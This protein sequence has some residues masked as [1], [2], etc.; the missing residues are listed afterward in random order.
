MLQQCTTQDGPQCQQWQ[1]VLPTHVDII[2]T[3]ATSAMSTTYA[4]L[5]GPEHCDEKHHATH[6]IMDHYVDGDGANSGPG[7]ALPTAMDYIQSKQ[8]DAPNNDVPE[9]L[10]NIGYPHPPTPELQ[11]IS[12]SDVDATGEEGDEHMDM[13]SPLA[14]PTCPPPETQAYQNAMFNQYGNWPFPALEV[15]HGTALIYDRV[16]AAGAPNYRGARIPLPS[17]LHLEVWAHEATGHRDDDTIINGVTYGFPIQY[18]GGPAYDKQPDTNHTSAEAYDAHVKQYFEKE[19]SECAM[20]GPF[21]S[22]PFT[23]WFR[24]SPIMTRPKSEPGKRHIIV[25]LSFPEGGINAHIQPHL[26]NGHEA[27]H[28]LP[29]IRDL[30]A[31]LKSPGTT[32]TLLAVIDISRA[33]RHFQVCPLDWPLLVLKYGDGYYFDRATP[34]GARMSSFVMQSAAQF[35]IRALAKRDIHALMYLDDLILITTHKSARAD[36]KA[37]CDLLARLG[38]EVAAHKLQPPARTVTWLGIVIDLD[39][40]S[41][42]IPPAKLSQIQEGLAHA[43]RQRSL[44]KKDLQRSIGQMSKTV[45]PARLFMGRLLA[46]LRGFPR[47]RIRVDRSMKADLA[48]FRRF[49]R[50]YNGRSIIPAPQESRE[51]WADAC[52]VGA[53]TTDGRSCYSYTLPLALRNNHHITHLEA[54]NCL[55]AARTLTTSEDRGR[56]IIINCDNLPAVDSYRGGGAR[57]P[58]LCACARAIWFLGA[59][60]EVDYQFNHIPEVLMDV[61][62]A[63]SRAMT[64]AKYRDKAD[65]YIEAMGLQ[66][67]NPAS[68]SFNFSAFYF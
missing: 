4:D 61:P 56:T 27:V 39:D 6:T 62:D 3:P 55:A 50:D 36:Y 51:I 54:I 43:S 42:S 7:D 12:G 26:F 24:A 41:I 47:Q 21:A 48:W 23:P 29:T 8:D 58:V 67:V 15:E 11:E 49:L 17:P 46:A 19:V 18:T 30:V 45:P 10:Q 25:D 13:H 20:A 37:T 33:Y 60:N 22:P 64:S 65:T 5:E 31:H 40:N 52:L 28:V 63:L 34:F 2:P 38:L 57:D 14:E 35:I 68:S 1:H 44:T 53:G 32:D 16:R 66:C 9:F 59:E